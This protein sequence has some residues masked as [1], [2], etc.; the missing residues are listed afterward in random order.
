MSDKI[1][2]CFVNTKGSWCGKEA[3]FEVVYGNAPSDVTESCARHIGELVDDRIERFE[4]GRISGGIMEGDTVKVSA[5]LKGAPDEFHKVIRGKN[6]NLI[7][8]DA[9]G[10]DLMEFSPEA[11]QKAE[12]CEICHGKGSTTDHHD[13]CTECGGKGYK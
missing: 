3:E 1:K 12:P 5:S 7:I 10:T 9:M 2:C 6:R 11:I 8:D 4:V 13:P